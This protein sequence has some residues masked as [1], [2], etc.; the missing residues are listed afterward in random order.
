MCSAGSTV[1]PMSAV[2]ELISAKLAIIA[3]PKG[4]TADGEGLMFDILKIALGFSFDMKPKYCQ[5]IPPSSLEAP[6]YI[7]PA[8]P[9]VK[10]T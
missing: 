8:N 9:S 3:S 7:P 6:K 1:I 2:V 4:L 5:A 10:G